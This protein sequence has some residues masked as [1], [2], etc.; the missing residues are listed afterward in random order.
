MYEMV[1][2]RSLWIFFSLLFLTR[3]DIIG[4]EGDSLNELK[5]AIQNSEL[6]DAKK[7]V[8]IDSLR[9]R[10]GKADTGN[11]KVYYD[12]NE[13]LYNEFKVFKRDSAFD[14]GL[15]T[16]KLALRI[17]DR[18]LVAIAKINLADISVSTGMYKE[19]LDFLTTIRPDAM[20][21]NIK[22]LYYGLLGRCY[23]DMAEYNNLSY[24]SDE[25]NL[26]AE[27]YRDSALI[28]TEKDTY[29]NSF[30]AAFIKFQKNHINESLN[31]FITISQQGL[32]LRDKAIVNYMI[33]N[34]YLRTG[35]NNKAISYFTISAIADVKTSTKESLAIIR[36]AEL[37]FKKGDI[38]TASMLIQKANEDAI[39]YGA[40]QRKIQV[41]SLLPL[42]EKEVI[43]IVEKQKDRLYIQN[44]TVSLLL[45]FVMALAYI[46]YRQMTKLKRAKNIIGVAHK[47][48]ETTNR[49]LIQVNKK[50]ELQNLELQ[51]VNDQLLEANKI[52]EEYIGFFFTQDADIFEKF[53]VF[54]TKV[55]KNLQEDNQS[56]LKHFVANYN[57]KKEK[58]NLLRNFDEAFIRLFPNYIAEFNSLMKKEHRIELKEGQLLNK[59]LRIFAL[60]RLGIKHNEIIAQIL[61]YSV[62][63][64]YAYKTQVRNKS[65][66]DKAGFD[67]KLLEITTIK[68]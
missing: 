6:Y 51:N 28:L 10:L 44:I 42:I 46:I 35:Q 23:G 60:I 18:E 63:S 45:L 33:G 62:N 48:L 57:L 36:L 47:N 13:K 40:Q 39:F 5:T 32:G 29:F 8:K 19:A 54:K 53:K 37:L 34:L 50:I 22:S 52:K 7:L 26:L 9:A 3:S 58:E 2:Y 67:S 31:D 30:L 55:E 4:Q 68:R 17:G 43:E 65:L 11:L 64:I 59:E 25:Y 20:P 15:K 16:D 27:R 56:K 49:K 14:Y 61:G 41:G 24:F 66:I 1:F 38:K 21:K 12:L